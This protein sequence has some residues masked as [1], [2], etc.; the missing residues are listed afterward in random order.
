MKNRVHVYH[1]HLKNA[2]AFFIVYF[3]SLQCNTDVT[4][5]YEN[6]SSVGRVMLLGALPVMHCIEVYRIFDCS[7]QLQK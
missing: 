1:I 5:F 6:I 2:Q 4:A 7:Y 3:I